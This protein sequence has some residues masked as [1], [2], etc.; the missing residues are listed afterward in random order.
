MLIFAHLGLTLASASLFS[1]MNPVMTLVALGALL[2]DIIDK[3]LGYILF[4]SASMGRI[5]AHTLLFL[6]VIMAL[7]AYR[8]NMASLA[9]GVFA[10]L[11]LDQM[12]SSPVILLWPLLGGFSLHANLGIIGYLES[13]FAALMNPAVLIPELLGF[14]YVLYLAFKAAPLIISGSEMLIDQSL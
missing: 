8:R 10:H 1:R 4:G 3:P 7:V 6:L 13:L 9:G 2:P 12:W 11:C 14:L 5:Y